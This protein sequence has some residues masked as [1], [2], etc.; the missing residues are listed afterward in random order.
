MKDLQKLFRECVLEMKSINMDISNN[1][2]SITVNRRLT[3]ALGRC[4]KKYTSYGVSFN[5]DI[6]PCMIEDGVE[7][8]ATKNVIMHELLHTCPGC[9]NHGSEWKYRAKIVNRKLGYNISTTEDTST[10]ES[11]GV[12]LTTREYKYALVCEKCGKQ[13]KKK[14]WCEAL[15][16]PSRYKCGVCEGRLYTICLDGSRN[17]LT[18]ANNIR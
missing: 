2:G 12:K 7:V 15:R 16:N 4:L 5:I 18:A 9:Y 3:R 10:L 11:S 8:K 6:N 17:V 13:Y 14:R 1:I